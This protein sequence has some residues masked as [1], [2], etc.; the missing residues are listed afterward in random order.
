[1]EK[2]PHSEHPTDIAPLWMRIFFSRLCLVLVIGGIWKH[3][4]RSWDWVLPLAFLG[5]FAFPAGVPELSGKKHWQLQIA[6]AL[7]MTACFALLVHF[8]GWVPANGHL[9]AS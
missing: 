1:M 6:L 9:A 7:W 8:W 4:P 5:G 3:G 2:R